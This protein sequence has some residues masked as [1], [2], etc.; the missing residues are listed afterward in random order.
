MQS[1]GS[2]LV[3]QRLLDMCGSI[4]FLRCAGSQHTPKRRQQVDGSMQPPCSFYDSP[5]WTQQTDRAWA[6]V[7][8][9]CAGMWAII[10]RL[11][12]ST[13][14]RMSASWCVYVMMLC[15]CRAHD[16][17]ESRH[18]ISAHV[19]PRSHRQ[20]VRGLTTAIWA[21]QRV[22][23]CFTGPSAGAGDA[24]RGQRGYHHVAQHRAAAQQV[25]AHAGGGSAAAGTGRAAVL[26]LPI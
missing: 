20:G 9:S 1:C 18:G 25:H 3:S 26:Q 24:A 16:R 12:S 14:L 15:L 11:L 4:H 10:R 17:P 8:I 21:I 6:Q 2:Y 22:F 7:N 19:H 5:C 23:A 13:A